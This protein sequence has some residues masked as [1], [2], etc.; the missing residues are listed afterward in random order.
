M[1]LGRVRTRLQGTGSSMG[2]RE[3]ILESAF[4]IVK[5]CYLLYYILQSCHSLF[6][7]LGLDWLSSSNP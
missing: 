3:L 6:K 5:L 4:T 1:R 7:G 2:P